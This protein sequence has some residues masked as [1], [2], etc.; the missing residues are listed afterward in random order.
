MTT[1]MTTNNNYSF[2]V[3]P[4]WVGLVIGTR[5][6]TLRSLETQGGVREKSLYHDRNPRLMGTFHVRGTVEEGMRIEELV[7]QLVRRKQVNRPPKVNPILS[8]ETRQRKKVTLRTYFSY[9]DS[10][11]NRKKEKWLA[12]H[13]TEEEKAA[14]LART[15]KPEKVEERPTLTFPPVGKG[16]VKVVLGEWGKDL[17]LVKSEKALTPPPRPDEG[18]EV[19]KKGEMKVEEEEIRVLPLKPSLLG[20]REIE[21]D[22]EAFSEDDWEVPEIEEDDEWSDGELEYGCF[23][24]E[25]DLAF[26]D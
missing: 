19:L 20:E 22:D 18:L 15:K 10:I 25:E 16:V 2:Q 24:D 12:H 7:R 6:A 9:D 14:Y 8:V 23:D 17:E 11:R 4:S 13:A 5:G 21:E 26:D 1:K 3:D